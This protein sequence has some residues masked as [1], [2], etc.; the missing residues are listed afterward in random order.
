MHTVA[1]ML[2]ECRLTLAGSGTITI[3][4]LTTHTNVTNSQL[5][6]VI[7]GAEMGLMAAHLHITDV[8]FSVLL[9]CEHWNVLDALREY[10]L[11]EALFVALRLWRKANPGGATYRA[12][13][14]IVLVMGRTDL[15][16]EL[17][18]FAALNCEHNLAYTV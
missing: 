6:A 7:G 4:E 18:K 2:T 9:G 14:E 13:V 11:Q 5:K 1:C 8:T 3:E 15:A 16:I 17:C 10:G 12:L